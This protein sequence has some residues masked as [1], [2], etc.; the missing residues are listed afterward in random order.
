[1]QGNGHYTRTRR[2]ESTKRA[3]Q[4]GRTKVTAVRGCEHMSGLTSLLL[5]FKQP[6]S[7]DWTVLIVGSN[8]SAS[9]H[10]GLW[11]GYDPPGASRW[12]ITSFYHNHTLLTP[13]LL[14]RSLE[15][16]SYFLDET[17]CTKT[18]KLGS[19]QV[20]TSYFGWSAKRK[21][22]VSFTVHRSPCSRLPIPD[23]D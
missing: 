3:S 22:K 6:G 9:H 19:L 8:A 2:G 13:V 1:M 15:G 12:A 20:R 5:P 4:A 14:W 11:L 16:Q 18:V 23:W 21:V 10:W 7:L 17:V